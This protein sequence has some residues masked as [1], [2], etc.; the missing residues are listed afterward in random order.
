MLSIILIDVWMWTPF[1][2]LISLAGLNAIPASIYEAAAVDR[3]TTWMVFRRI[4]LPM[5]APLVGLA[6]LLR[7]TDALKQFDLV[8]AITGPNDGASQTLSALL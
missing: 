2:I 1:T 7:A 5:S 4:T 6:A 8:M 3:A